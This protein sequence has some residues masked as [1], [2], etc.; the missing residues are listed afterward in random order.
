MRH[1]PVSC[2]GGRVPLTVPRAPGNSAASL[3]P[4]VAVAHGS[5][6][7]RATATVA[8]LLGVARRR[9]AG[10]GLPGIEARAAY[11]GH[12]PPTLAQALSALGAPA[13]GGAAPRQRARPAPAAAPRPGAPAGGG[14]GGPAPAPQ[15]RG[16]ARRGGLSRP[17]GTRGR[18]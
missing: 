7:P 8:A 6:D 10:A 1:P 5:A 12:A 11:L 13:E 3:P 2:G 9:A 17:A 18:R 14:R 4:L 16:R 15:H